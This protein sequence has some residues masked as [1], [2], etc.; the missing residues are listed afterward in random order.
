MTESYFALSRS[1]Q[2]N[3]LQA[4]AMELGY[5]ANIL[6]KDIWICWVLKILFSMPNRHAM[7]FKGGTSL[8]KIYGLI[9]RFS[10]D[11]DLSIDYRSLDQDSD[12]IGKSRSQLK[13]LSERLKAAIAEHANLQIVPFLRKELDK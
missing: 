11:I 12:F 13:K 10:E 3:L 2:R 8:S 4:A 1:K 6:E 7:A 9:H 5:P